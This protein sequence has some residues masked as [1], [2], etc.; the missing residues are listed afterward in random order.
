MSLINR[1]LSSVR[2]V[3]FG[4]E[5]GL[6]STL[7]VVTGVAE[8]TNDQAIVIL[9]GLVVIMV[10]SLS[11]A[12]GTYLSNKS[13]NQLFARVLKPKGKKIHDVKDHLKELDDKRPIQASMVMFFSYFVGGSVPVF[14][15][16][17]LPPTSGLVMSVFLTVI[18]LFIVGAVKGKIVGV[19][20][21]RS[22][23]EMM[24]VSTVAA[25]VGFVIGRVARQLLLA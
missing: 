17:F 13:E 4:L 22:G 24:V 7:G 2:E 12:A 11:M 8:G 14:P 25:G 9:T 15:Y 16:F 6:V 5:D 21:L 23:L 20:A 1:A 10:E 3:I 19:S 18:A